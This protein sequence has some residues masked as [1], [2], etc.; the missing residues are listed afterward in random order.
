[1]LTNFNFPSPFINLINSIF[2]SFNYTPILNGQKLSSFKPLCDIRQGDLISP[3][4][5]IIAMEFLNHSILHEVKHK[6][7]TPFTLKNSNCKM[8]F[9]HIFFADDILLFAKAT[10]KNLNSIQNCLHTFSHFS[11]LS[12]NLDKSKI[13]FS[14]TV[15]LNMKNY[16]E[17]SLSINS[18]NSLGNYLGLPLKPI[19][20][21]IVK[22][23][24]KL[25]GWKRN[26][27]SMAD[28]IQLIN[29][30]LSTLPSHAMQSF[31]L[32]SSI[33]KKID[34]I[35][36]NSFW[37]HDHNIKKLHHIRWDHIAKPKIHGGLGIRKSNLINATFMAKIKWNN[38]PTKIIFIPKLL[39]LNMETT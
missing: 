7:W 4:L 21:I 5:F 31:S 34:S 8:N 2:H 3:Y 38:S 23:L 39:G 12:I 6:N 11:N 36:Q 19:N 15:P 26:S 27:L 22:M 16:N 17:T 37:G 13:W 35:N 24:N 29:S 18:T 25:Q 33:L 28:C 30:N 9:S 20:F 10:K 1:M 32:P 14:K